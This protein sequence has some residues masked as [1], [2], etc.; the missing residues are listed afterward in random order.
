LG[1]LAY[2]CNPNYSGSGFKASPGKRLATPYLKNKIPVIS[3]TRI[4]E[5]GGPQ[6]QAS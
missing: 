1:V 4:A 5:V 2:A 3:A 6:S